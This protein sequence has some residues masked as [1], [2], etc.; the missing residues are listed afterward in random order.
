MSLTLDPCRALQ[1]LLAKG[2]MLKRALGSG[3]WGSN[4]G[5]VWIY[6]TYRMDLGGDFRVLKIQVNVWGKCS[7]PVTRQRLRSGDL[8]LATDSSIPLTHKN[9]NRVTPQGRHQKWDE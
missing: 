5:S 2:G 1:G 4:L 8:G 3:S 7:G 9:R 6:P